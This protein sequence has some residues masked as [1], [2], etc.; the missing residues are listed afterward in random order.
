[1]YDT[2]ESN[3]WWFLRIWP[4]PKTPWTQFLKFSKRLVQHFSDPKASGHEIINLMRCENP[5]I[6]AQNQENF[7]Y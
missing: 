3:V 2:Y 1:M 7:V 5:Y 6:A 4:V